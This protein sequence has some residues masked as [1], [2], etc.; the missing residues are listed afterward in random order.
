MT[1]VNMKRKISKAWCSTWG[2][3]WGLRDP[4][5]QRGGTLAFPRH[6]P[7]SSFLFLLLAKKH[8]SFKC[9]Q[10]ERGTILEGWA[11]GKSAWQ[12]L[13]KILLTPYS[14]TMF[15]WSNSERIMASLS[16]SEAMSSLAS[17]CDQRFFKS[18]IVLQTSHSHCMIAHYWQIKSWMIS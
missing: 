2:S 7:A 18:N 12:K 4:W 17:S 11:P 6:T 9:W 3:Y 14:L 13:L 1:T 5:T 10:K 8:D 15:G 16:K